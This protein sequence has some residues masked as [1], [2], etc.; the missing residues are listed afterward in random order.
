VSEPL[1]LI[2]FDV[3]GTL[4]DS[5]ASI[6]AAMATSF[7]AAL[8]ETGVDRQDSVMIGDT[9]FA[10]LHPTLNQFWNAPT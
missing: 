2:R 5:Q 6:V 4:V 1:R 8:A 10:D 7:K 9:S 3:G